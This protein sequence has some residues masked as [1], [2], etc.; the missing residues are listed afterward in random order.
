MPG[1]KSKL[2]EVFDGE[3]ND[4]QLKARI[5]EQDTGGRHA[6]TARFFCN[7][8][9]FYIFANQTYVLTNQ[10]GKGTLET[11]SLLSEAYPDLNIKYDA[12][13]A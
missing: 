5:M 1:G 13:Y 8:G 4:E 2:Y 11:I 7:K 3:L 6:R 9:E 12:V 10:W